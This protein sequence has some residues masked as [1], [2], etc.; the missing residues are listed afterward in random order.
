MMEYYAI[1]VTYNPEISRLVQNIDNLAKQGF[2]VV[3]VDNNSENRDIIKKSE[4]TYKGIYLDK[5]YGIAKALN[6]GME[7]AVSKGA[8]WILSSDQDTIIS[9]NILDEYKKYISLKDAGALC[10]S[11]IRGDG[12][13]T[14]ID[15]EYVAVERCPTSGFFLSAKAWNEGCRYDEWMFIDYV[16]Y[17]I[18]IQLKIKGYKIYQ[19]RDTYIIQNLGNPA[20]IKPVEKIGKLIGSKKLINLSHTYNH[21]PFRNYYF[22]RNSLYYQYK[23]KKHINYKK[24]RNFFIKWE[25]KKLLLE[26]HKVLLVKSII[27]G[28]HD[29]AT[30][31]KETQVR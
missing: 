30:H 1:I 7:Y 19:I 31:I 4:Q 28:I 24:E 23:Y 29:C 25:V 27:R 13:R 15:A 6:V 5:N 3:I 14:K 2:S 22:V 12:F 16:D 9:D 17:D 26:K 18:C 21:T 10:P 8:K 20:V 11:V